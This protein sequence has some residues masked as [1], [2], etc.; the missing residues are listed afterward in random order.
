MLYGEFTHQIDS[1]FRIRIPFRFKDELGKEYV[2]YRAEKG[3]IAIYSAERAK[4]KFGFL[5][6]V[7]PFDRQA[8][9]FAMKFLKN[10]YNAED[11][12]QG[13]VIIPEPLRGE[14][15]G[16]DVVSIGAGDHIELMSVE[17]SEALKNADD[18]PACMEFL[19][20]MYNES[21]NG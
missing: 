12:G 10:L 2:F 17:R 21:K 11:D 13:R 14:L 6:N 4:Q 15:D 5:E 8:V 7:S 20:K 18:D 3:I 9:A 19:N 1:R 16:K